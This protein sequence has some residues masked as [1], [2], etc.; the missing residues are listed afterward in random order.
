MSAPLYK[1]AIAVEHNP[2]DPKAIGPYPKGEP[3]GVTL[4]EWLAQ[5]GRGRYTCE[6]GKG[7]IALEFSALIPDG[8]YTMWYVFAALPPTEPFSGNLDV[9]FGARDGSENSFVADAEGSARFDLQ[10][11][12]CLQL[13]ED[14]TTSL[15]AINYHSNGKTYKA[16][17]GPFGIHAHVPL[18]VKLPRADEVKRERVAQR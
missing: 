12:P 5:R 16:S 1:T 14:W 15:I 4:E 18:F 17:P 7:N 6:E 11:S 13:T 10:F 8:L 9:P 3:L 2:F